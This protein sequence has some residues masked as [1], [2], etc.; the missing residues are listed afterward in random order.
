MN[1]RAKS[2]TR[3]SR[4]RLL[5]RK[6]PKRGSPKRRSPKRRSPKRRSPKRGSPKRGSP[7]RRSPKRRS[8]KRRSPKR[9]SPKRG[10]PKRGS[11]KRGSL[12]HKYS[13]VR[14]KSHNMLRGGT[15]VD[16]RCDKCKQDLPHGE[17]I[18]GSKPWVDKWIHKDRKVCGI[19]DMCGEHLD[20]KDGVLGTHNREGWLIDKDRKVCGM[21][22][23][24]G[25]HLDE[26]D[27]VL[28]KQYGEDCW[29]HANRTVCSDNVRKKRDAERKAEREKQVLEE[30][31]IEEKNKTAAKTR[32][33]DQTKNNGAI[34]LV[35]DEMAIEIKRLE[36]LTLEE[37]VAEEKGDFF[38]FPIAKDFV[39][40]GI[41]HKEM[42]N[43]E[44]FKHREDKLRNGTISIMQSLQDP[45]DRSSIV[46]SV[47]SINKTDPKYKTENSIEIHCTSFRPVHN[48]NDPPQN[49]YGHV[50]LIIHQRKTEDGIGIYTKKY[51]YGVMPIGEKEVIPDFTRKFWINKTEII[52]KPTETLRDLVQ[53]TPENMRLEF[54][55]PNIS[56]GDLMIKYYN[57][58][59]RTCPTNQTPYKLGSVKSLTRWGHELEGWHDI[60]IP[61]DQFVDFMSRMKRIRNRNRKQVL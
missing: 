14:R 43:R 58:C 25:E 15:E 38:R 11:R 10:S 35:R 39:E 22:D 51:H 55:F 24:C 18:N 52:K 49:Y 44:N 12:K 5:N 9:G 47:D 28:G 59:I 36:E 21:C 26:K 54:L 56:I 6:S 42:I 3:R 19:C 61:Q 4:S 27:G 29:M 1:G 23:V 45:T 46:Y 40:A 13:S 7:K 2:P 41:M 17:G 60:D 53:L 50:T 34:Q 33:Y 57:W 20:E 48:V 37:R 30:Q 16:G 31:I 8:P 32:Y